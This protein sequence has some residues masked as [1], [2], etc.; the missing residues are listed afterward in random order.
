[1]MGSV[2]AYG[3]RFRVWWVMVALVVAGLVVVAAA[4]RASADVSPAGSRVAEAAGGSG[5][6]S[7]VMV[8]RY[9]GVQFRSQLDVYGAWTDWTVL[10][11]QTLQ[12]VAM[13]PNKDGRLEV[14]GIRADQSIWHDWQTSVGG[15]W[16]GWEQ[17]DGALSS[18][19]VAKELDGR[20]EVF[21]ANSGDGVFRMWQNQAGVDSWSGW[22]QF[23]GALR[24]VAAETDANGLVEVF[25][26]TS[27]QTIFYRHQTQAGLDSW[28]PWQQLAGTLTSIAAARNGF[29]GPLELVGTDAADQIFT[30]R[31]TQV[32]LDSW[33]QPTQISGLLRSVAVEYDVNNRINLFG[34]TGAET[35]FQRN[36]TTANV[37]TWTDWAQVHPTY[38][39]AILTGVHAA[40]TTVSIGFTD[41]SYDENTFQIL[42]RTDSGPLQPV[43]TIASRNPAGAGDTYTVTDTITA[44]ARVC[45]EIADYDTID[46][47]PATGYSNEVCTTPP[48]L[49]STP[50]TGIGLISTPDT[51][52]AGNGSR[53]SGQENS[54]TIGPD[55][56]PLIA[57]YVH[58][59]ATGSGSGALAVAHCSDALCSSATV[60]DLDTS[61]DTG[62]HPS[63]AIGKD[64]LAVISYVYWG[65]TNLSVARYLKVAHCVDPL[66]SSATITTLDSTPYV[67]NTAT[68]IGADGLPAIA[69]LD[70]QITQ[71]TQF[72]VIKVA[73]CSN[74]ACTAATTT[75]VDDVPTRS[76]TSLSAASG[77]AGVWYIAYTGNTAKM[78]TCVTPD[79]ANPKIVPIT[80]SSASSCSGCLAD[81]VSVTV[82]RDGLPLISVNRSDG[83]LYIA[84]CV[85][86]WCTRI[87]ETIPEN[88]VALDVFDNK[89]TIGGDGFG[90]VT[91]HDSTN[92]NLQVAH[93]V[94]LA[95]STTTTTVVDEF[96]DVG[97]GSSATAGVDGLPVIT[98]YDGTS[99]ALKVIHCADVACSM[100]LISPFQTH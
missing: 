51:T 4:P 78:A 1:M 35:F 44:G 32:G 6:L 92:L 61:G 84:H 34:V 98:Y 28:T 87:T 14:F 41:N 39:P 52:G 88:G 8:D 71:T 56:L 54:V 23:D 86:V 26:V 12:S 43:T 76:G 31:Q 67:E 69:Y 58:N 47:T 25:G 93:C 3:R 15:P 20:L 19:A 16:S 90:L 82:G 30:I 99:G 70:Y 100:P 40:G 89:V 38:P 21:G 13:E 62:G 81:D 46:P 75:V 85:N 9:G 83:E 27:S 2:A 53:R 72:S 29:K 45:Y 97:E 57:Y 48:A 79:C 11:G 63:I 7:M 17:M 36:Q 10:L 77:G 59:G 33:S 50:A 94:D 91:Y 22:T 55:G 5:L 49:P 42:R 24:S 64:G 60:H 66:C 68:V 95:C 80:E 74:P 73:H 37:D 18:I 65:G 96:D